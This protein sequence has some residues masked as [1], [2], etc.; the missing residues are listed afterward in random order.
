MHLQ[1]TKSVS[2]ATGGPQYYFHNVP[3]PVKEFLRRRGACPVV[4]QTPYGIA[5]S[6]FTAVG[7]DHKLSEKGRVVAGKVGHDRIQGTESIGEAIRYWYGLKGGRDFARIDVDAVFHPD[8]HFILIPTA[9]TMRGA[10]RPFTL[11]KAISP[12]SFHRDH[13][14]KLWK[15]QIDLRREESPKDVSW[16]GL[17]L[18]RIVTQQQNVEAKNVHEADLLRASGALSILG[19]DLSLYLTRGYDCPESRFHFSSLPPYPCPVEIKK[20]SARFDYQMTHY[21]ELPRAVVLC[22]KHDLINPPDHV[23]IVELSTLAE[24]LT[25]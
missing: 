9:V 3:G 16:A 12:L 25:H 14:S 8:G 2:R 21:T 5:T 4:L 7:R 23:D 11:E 17:Q 18:K 24:Y 10:K 1:Q 13:Q 19:L 15:R 6:S 22:V 20:R